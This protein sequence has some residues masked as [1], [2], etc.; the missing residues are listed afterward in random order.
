MAV[1]SAL[2]QRNIS[3]RGRLLRSWGRSSSLFVESE[4][5][6]NRF[7]VEIDGIPYDA[8]FVFKASGYN[9][10]P[11]EMGAAFGIVQ[12]NKLGKNI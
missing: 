2:I 4:K 12:L 11:S 10:E 7:N 5:I 9:L 1:C 6:E 8:K 3:T